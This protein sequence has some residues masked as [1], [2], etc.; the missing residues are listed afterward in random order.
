[1]DNFSRIEGYLDNTMP[2]SERKVFEAD[3]LTDPT[4]SEALA[5]LREA[6][7]RLPS[8]WSQNEQEAALARTLQAWGDQYFGKAAPPSRRHLWWWLALAAAV[9]VL[10]L[11]LAWPRQTQKSP[12]DA[13]RVFAQH[14]SP[15]LDFG[16]ARSQS[17]DG[18]DT[19]AL[20]QSAYLS[21][22]YARAIALLTPRVDGNTATHNSFA[23]LQLGQLYL[24][25]R[26]PD[27]ARR[28]LA[29]V[30][31]GYGHQRDWYLAMSALAANAPDEA[32]PMLQRIAA[33]SGPFQAKAREVLEELK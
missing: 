33:E 3:L 11:W 17:P 14:F 30:K 5:H 4:L 24:L 29:Q 15:S 13:T 2:E 12:P 1:M 18:S 26:Q 6:R 25:N 19:L 9:A 28:A 16:P 23:Y 7:E 20:L 27:A 22:D 21:G 31:N 32:K 8:Q 10:A